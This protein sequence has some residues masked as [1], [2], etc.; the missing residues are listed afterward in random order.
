MRFTTGRDD[1]LAMTNGT[2]LLIERAHQRAIGSATEAIKKGWR[3]QV[4]AAGLGA[5][6]PNTIRSR[7]YPA[8]QP[9]MDAAGLV[10]ARSRGPAKIIG[11]FERGVT[12]RSRDG[13]WLA[14]PTPEAG[15]GRFGRK[16]TP[17]TWERHTGLRLRFVYRPG[18][19]SLLVTD[20]ARV[21]ARG[22]ARRKGGRRRK[23]DGILSGEQTVVI[24]VLVP[25]ARISKRL[26]L[27]RQADAIAGG[28]VSR[29]T[30]D[31]LI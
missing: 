29:V 23:T 24:F 8:G 7:V 30:L 26:D 4:R 19:S 18:Q 14:I 11:S 31:G 27:I 5:K 12:I 20:G 13:F 22:Q 21:N 25:Q 2:I 17:L 1:M 16:F 6:L 9:S 3:G 10:Y 15:R 28:L